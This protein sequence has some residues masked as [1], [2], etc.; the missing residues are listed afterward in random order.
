MP[1]SRPPQPEGG[2]DFLW[3]SAV[4]AL[5]CPHSWSPAFPDR[6][7]QLPASPVPRG[8]VSTARQLGLRRPQSPPSRQDPGS[9]GSV[10]STA[11]VPS[12]QGHT[13][14]QNAVHMSPVPLWT[15]A[16]LTGPREQGSRLRRKTRTLEVLPPPHATHPYKEA[17]LPALPMQHPC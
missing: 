1:K 3:Y 17:T 8:L 9:V 2:G 16:T 5:V 14:P 12:T 6:T 11:G 15:G 13:E 7:Q 10:R 4:F